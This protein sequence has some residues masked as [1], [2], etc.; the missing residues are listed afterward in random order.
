MQQCI[1]EISVKN[2]EFSSR[3]YC[4]LCAIYHDMLLE[5]RMQ[6]LL[7]FT[8]E[9]DTVTRPKWLIMTMALRRQCVRPTQNGEVTIEEP[10]FFANNRHHVQ[11]DIARPL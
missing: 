5:Q 8:S 7:L 1:D 9:F 6:N 3:R 2:D 10:P 11:K 4:M